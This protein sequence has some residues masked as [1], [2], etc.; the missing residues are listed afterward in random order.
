[1]GNLNPVP[2]TFLLHML[3]W[4]FYLL[5]DNNMFVK[6]ALLLYDCLPIWPYFF[7]NV[8]GGVISHN[9]TLTTCLTSFI[10]KAE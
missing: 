1:V 4:V 6:L 9:D 5:Y 3:G 10:S 2:G 8:T 7:L